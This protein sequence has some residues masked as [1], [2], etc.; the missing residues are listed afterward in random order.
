M[1][2]AGVKTVTLHDTEV[3]QLRD[4]GSQFYLS[5]EDIGANRASACQAKLQELNTA[6]AVTATAQDLDDGFL[7]GFDVRGI[8]SLQAVPQLPRFT[9][10]PGLSFL[11]VSQGAVDTQGNGDHESTGHCCHKH[12]P[13]GVCKGGR[14]LQAAGHRIHSRRAAR[15]FRQRVLRFRQYLHGA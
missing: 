5:E 13:G 9:S 3:V 4:L 6:V 8:V 10:P 15:R 1:I 7:A 12:G 14:G 11:H 2:L